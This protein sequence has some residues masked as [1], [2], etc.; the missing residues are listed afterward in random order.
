MVG[1][2]GAR[3]EAAT[4]RPGSD[5]GGRAFRGTCNDV[6]LSRRVRGE[7]LEELGKDK[8]IRPECKKKG[9]IRVQSTPRL[10]PILTS[11]T[12][13]SRLRCF[14]SLHSATPPS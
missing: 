2:D 1:V 9:G 12:R 13:T 11:N 7:D 14:I 3:T 10:G 8:R 4:H 5:S 6:A